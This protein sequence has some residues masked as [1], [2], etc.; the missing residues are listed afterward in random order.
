M[1]TYYTDGIISD[2]DYNIKSKEYAFAYLLDH[3]CSRVIQAAGYKRYIV[4]RHRYFNATLGMSHDGVG[5]EPGRQ[6][7][8]E[9]HINNLWGVIDDITIRVNGEEKW[10]TCS[11]TKND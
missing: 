4:D 6:V 9:S 1:I 8:I 2:P 5:P 7:S 11:G 10:Q 3:S